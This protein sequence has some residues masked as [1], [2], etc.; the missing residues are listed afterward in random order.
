MSKINASDGALAGETAGSGT[1]SHHADLPPLT[2][3]TSPS[4][5]TTTAQPPSSESKDK[6]SQQPS[7]SGES[8]SRPQSQA[9]G[10]SEFPQYPSSLQYTSVRDFAYPIS[11]PLHYGPPPEPSAPPSGM[12]TPT[13]E[14]GF[15]GYDDYMPS[16]Q[17]F[18]GGEPPHMILSHGPPYR[19][20]DDLQSPVVA[21]RHRRNRSS[22]VGKKSDQELSLPD[23]IDGERGFNAAAGGAQYPARRSRAFHFSQHPDDDNRPSDS[24]LPSS[25]EGAT[26][27][28]TNRYSRD[29]QFTIT[30]PDEEFHGKAVAL[31]DFERENENELPLIEGQIIWVSYRHGQGWL[32]AEDPKTRESGLVPEEYVRLLRDIEGGMHSLTGSVDAS[33]DSDGEG[34]PAG[35]MS[36]SPVTYNGGSANG[37]HQPIV[38]T[39]STSSKDLNPYPTEQLGIQAGQVPPQVVHYHGQHGGSG[40]QNPTPTIAKKDDEEKKQDNA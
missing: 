8:S 36:L 34:V 15:S 25:P 7:G 11:N 16:W 27:N 18:R 24:E 22:Q 20:D 38:S 14:L 19:E 40:S 2:T 35:E 31:F 26:F 1:K 39:F 4:A 6:S 5:S 32:V 3:T 13:N 33:T 28:E 23:E 21:T 9:I 37:Y 30:S 17:P 10:E 29:Y 12:T